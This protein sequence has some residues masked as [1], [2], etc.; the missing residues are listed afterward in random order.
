MARVIDSLNTRYH[1]I[2]LQIFAVVVIAHWAEHIAQAVQIFAL[3]MP[4]PESRGV[5]G[6]FF[7]WLVSSEAL[8]Y[9]YAIF[10]LV[11][12]ILLRPGFQGRSRTWWN[13]ALGIQVWHH[14]EHFLLLSQVVLHMNLLGSPMQTSILQ[15]FIP[16]V[17]LHLFYNA[18]VFA[19]MVMAMY[20][21][22]FPPAGERA[23]PLC[24]CVKHG[25]VSA[26]Q[27]PAS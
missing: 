27:I 11:G 6:M 16:R 3:G 15:L 1:E 4:R 18:I 8:H 13:V 7:P 24:T 21:H 23:N 17:E 20:F 22:M 12:L 5:L 26:V 14:F 10:M 19:P 2:A 9:F 25:H